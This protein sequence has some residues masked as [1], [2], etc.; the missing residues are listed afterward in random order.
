MFAFLTLL[1]LVVATYA[2]SF[3][4]SWHLDD[5]PNITE[6]RHLQIK[7][8]SLTQILRAAF[9][10]PS[11][12]TIAFYRPISRLSLGLNYYFGGKE[13]FGYH[14]V[15][16]IIHICASF[17]LYLF[18]LHTL[19]LPLIGAGKKSFFIAL[20]AAAFWAIH[21]IQTQAVTYIVQRM[22]S[23]AGMFTIMAMY[24][25]VRSRVCS[26]RRTRAS[27]LI[28]CGIAA[29]FGFGSKE[30]AILLPAN[31]FLF[32]VLIVKG[33]GNGTWKRDLKFFSLFYLVPLLAFLT[34][35]QLS[36][37]VITRVFELYDTRTF[38]LLERLLTES[39][40]IA[41][42]LSL[43]LY[44]MN[45]RLSVD[46]DIALSTS[47][48][49]PP[50]TA[51]SILLI[52]G[53][54]LT[55]YLQ[56]GKR[57]LISFSLL[58]FLLNHGLESTILP[59][60]LI[61]EHRNY[62]PSMPFFIPI[63]AG[64]AEVFSPFRSN[65][66][67]KVAVTSSIS[68]ILLVFAHCAFLRNSVWKD[69]RSLW[70]DVRA[71]YPQSFRAHHNL[72]RY[73]TLHGEEKK[74]EKEYFQALNGR[75]THRRNEKAITF[76]NLGYLAHIQGDYEM[77]AD[78]YR[79]ALG[80]DRCC[81]KANNNLA[82]VLLESGNTSHEEV[83]PILEKALECNNES[84]I[85]HALSNMG[86]LLMRMGKN[87]EAM[88]ALSKAMEVDPLNRMNL[89]R[90]GYLLEQSGEHDKASLHFRRILEIYRGD[91]PAHLF[92]AQACLQS[93]RTEEAGETLRR[94]LDAVTPD[95]LLSYL[96][97]HRLHEG[98]TGAEVSPRMALLMPLLAKACKGKSGYERISGV[99]VNAGNRES[100]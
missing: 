83:L 4:A 11:S 1:I 28:L 48:W 73:Y 46:H 12:N 43:L 9:S 68:L 93:G 91:I 85:P 35:L 98:E 7:D 97:K 34:Y 23:L 37:Q 92:L 5:E 96:E 30:N 2:N 25:Y 3:E 55:S 44:P 62:I 16:L 36:H 14:L 56:A 50:S 20:S 13:V 69:E 61:F 54:L 21:P 24:F 32:H 41:F 95:E 22:T 65:R 79:K 42:Y 64:I 52:L 76:F 40:A 75:E 31:L 71:K 63:F 74:A 60:E 27:L 49:N 66:F 72:G 99:C 18:T 94:L 8:L 57:P 45:Y 87:A 82:A 100:E 17:F 80:L 86:L 29:I 53:M 39:R 38:T 67:M 77:A 81:P 59:M 15:N 58:F 6:N 47:L 89:L 10:A 33:V 26:G 19:N 70:E 78:F 51:L 88:N 84:E 90:M